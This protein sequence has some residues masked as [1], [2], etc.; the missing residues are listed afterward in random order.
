VLVIHIKKIADYLS[1]SKKNETSVLKL[2]RKTVHPDELD[3]LVNAINTFR[4][5]LFEANKKLSSINHDLE[6]KV[7]DRTRQLTTKNLSLEKA[8]TQIK[9]MQATL[10]AQERL[11]S[12][13]S[14][15]ASVAHEI[16][17]PLNF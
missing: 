7:E 10:V 4:S 2:S 3:I 13:G 1:S 8:M 15:T 9:R 16:R 17:N 6:A 11:A 12:L 5:D 14:L